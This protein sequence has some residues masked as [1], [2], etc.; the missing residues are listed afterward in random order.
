M[1]AGFTQLKET[2]GFAWRFE[3]KIHLPLQFRLIPLERV[4]L[5]KKIKWNINPITP[6]HHLASMYPSRLPF[7]WLLCGVGDIWLSLHLRKTWESFS[8]VPIHPEALSD[9][10]SSFSFCFALLGAGCCQ[11][12]LAALRLC[13]K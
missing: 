13:F 11:V 7:L 2:Q 5:R 6:L 10:F 12:A 1:E 8:R 9:I 4:L 3:C